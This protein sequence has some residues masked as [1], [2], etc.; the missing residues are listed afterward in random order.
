[1]D[2]RRYCPSRSFSGANST[3]LENARLVES[4]QLR[5]SRE[6]T[7]GEISTRI[8]AVTNIE[9]IMQ[10]AVEELGRKI[11]GATEVTLELDNSN[12]MEG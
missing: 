10:A 12:D 11:G 9:A 7:I 6:R 3:R 1:M 4:S 8:G 5:A 2:F